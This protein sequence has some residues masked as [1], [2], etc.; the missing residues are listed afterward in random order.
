MALKLSPP[1]GERTWYAIATFAAG[2][3]VAITAFSRHNNVFGAMC[4]VASACGAGL[5]F[6][7]QWARWLL[8]GLFVLMSG[9]AVFTLATSGFTWVRLLYVLAPLCAAWGVWRE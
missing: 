8:I 5:W 2:I 4:L 7:Q 3:Y 1:G 9:N 6:L